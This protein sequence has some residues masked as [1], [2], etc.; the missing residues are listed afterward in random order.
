M[1]VLDRKKEL[2]RSGERVFPNLYRMATSDVGSK[3]PRPT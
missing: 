2:S 3:D 1:S